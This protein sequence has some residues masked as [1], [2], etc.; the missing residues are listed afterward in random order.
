[1]QKKAEQPS[2]KSVGQQKIIKITG[3]NT[4]IAIVESHA[5]SQSG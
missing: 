4:A 2:S 5:M 3:A 1:M